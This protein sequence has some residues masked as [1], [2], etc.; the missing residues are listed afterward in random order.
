MFESINQVNLAL[1]GKETT[2]IYC[3]EKM[4]SFKMKL[5]LWSLKLNEKNLVYFPTLN[6]FIDENNIVICDDII[7]IMKLHISMLGSEISHYFPNLEE[8][9]KYT[10]F[11][12]NP[13]KL[14]ICNLPS[15]GNIF[16]KQLIDLM[17]DG[18]V[19]IIFQSQSINCFWVEMA[20]IYPDVAKKALK[21]LI[22]F[23]TTYECETA[24]SSLVSIKTKFR[25]RLDVGDEMRVALATTEPDFDELINGKQQHPSH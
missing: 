3:Q 6:M 9:Q 8:I 17:N 14:Q 4:I 2:V 20:Y 23:A 18:N 1:Q 7:K 25:N 16:Q 5:E 22:P 10:Q 24:F 19:K 11:I 13:F 12:S 15:E 21:I